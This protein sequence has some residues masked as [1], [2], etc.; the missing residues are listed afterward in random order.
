MMERIKRIINPIKGM[1]KE[2]T[3]FGLLIFVVLTVPSC[4]SSSDSTKSSSYNTNPHAQAHSEMHQEFYREELTKELNRRLDELAGLYTGTIPCNDCD[5]I[6]MELELAADMTYVLK[7]TYVG[8]SEPPVRYT[9]NFILMQD[10]L[11]QLDKKQDDLYYFQKEGDQLKVLDKNGK[12]IPG[13]LRGKYVLYYI[14]K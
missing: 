11:I 9:G 6:E 13:E 10:W 4:G 5:G 8:K 14:K 1:N 7:K 12:L 2:L 3:L